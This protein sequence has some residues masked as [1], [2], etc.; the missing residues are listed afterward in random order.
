MGTLG[1]QHTCHI[2][3][4]VGQLCVCPTLCLCHSLS[5]LLYLCPT[6]FM[7]YS[8]YVLLCLCPT[9]LCPTRLCH[10]LSM[11][12]SVYVILCLCPTLSMSYSS[13]SYSAYVLLVYALLCQCLTLSMPYS[14]YVLLCQCPT[15]ATM[16]IFL[17]SIYVLLSLYCDRSR[18]PID[19]LYLPMSS[20]ICCF[21]S[22]PQEYH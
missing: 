18:Y 14:V 4:C 3:K 6:L 19:I 20:S 12:Y 11:S 5:I 1:S 16:S 9:R 2:D 10:T 21:Q 15:N 8:V 7:S 13:M 22:I 17:Y